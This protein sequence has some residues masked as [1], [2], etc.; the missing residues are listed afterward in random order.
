MDFR[1][2]AGAVL[3]PILA[4]L[5]IVLSIPPFLWHLRN[6]NVAACS[7]IFWITLANVFVFVNA[8]I[9]PTD[10]V[11]YWFNGVGLCD[12][13]VKLTWA[14]SVGAAASLTCIM[15][16]LA[17]IMDVDRTTVIPTRAQR[18]RQMVVDFLWCYGCPFYLMIID[19]V[20][21]SNRYYIFTVSGCTPAVD[22]SWLT[23]VL[24]FI[25]APLFCLLGAYYS[26]LV[27][28]RL[29]RYRIQFSHILSSSNSKMNKSRFIR[30]FCISVTLLVILLPVQL[31]ILNQNLS[32]PRH[33]YSWS[34][35]HGPAWTEIIMVPTGGQVAFDRWIRVGCG[36]LFFLFFGTGNDAKKMYQT[37]L[38]KIGLGSVFP[39]LHQTR[40]S[41][42]GT[43][44][45]GSGGSASAGSRAKLVFLKSSQT[46]ATVSTSTSRHDSAGTELTPPTSVDPKAPHESAFSISPEM[47][48]Q[49]NTSEFAN[50]SSRGIKTYVTGGKRNGSGE[51]NSSSQ[52]AVKVT[53]NVAQ[54]TSFPYIAS[55]FA[56][57]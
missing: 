10:D 4:V 21:Q 5:A 54:T 31:Y 23:I 41:P 42:S 25:W 14:F 57:E 11:K 12:V 50:S 55:E 20:V 36:L 39:R 7:L 44:V 22:N 38:L 6:R 47:S 15:R 8:L 18:R 3:L 56:R 9:W 27:V 30:L 33:P 43:G 28:I 52:G 35:V 32:Y 40:P 17:K 48:Q 13:E 46:N 51:R 37:W 19:Y 1:P 2:S 26:V 49:L 24:I 53:S 29:Y 34:S 45:S 16:N